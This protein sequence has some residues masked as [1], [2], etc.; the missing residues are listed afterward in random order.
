MSTKS[1][2]PEPPKA[3]PEPEPEDEPAPEGLVEDA[4]DE[5]DEARML[6]EA[7]ARVRRDNPKLAELTD[8]IAE[9]IAQPHE[10]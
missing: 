6:A 10:T 2:P 3:R 8:A 4:P 7:R 5:E 9:R 1:P